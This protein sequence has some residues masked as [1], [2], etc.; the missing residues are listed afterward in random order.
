[1]ISLWL[2]QIMVDL[3]EVTSCVTCL[4][5]GLYNVNIFDINNN[6]QKDTN[7][8]AVMTSTVQGAY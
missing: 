8:A 1:M 2:Y 4:E 3:N 5:T 6:G 7:G